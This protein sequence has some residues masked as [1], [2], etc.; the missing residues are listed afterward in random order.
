MAETVPLV[1]FALAGLLRADWAVGLLF[2]A[3][4]VAGL[5]VSA[6]SGWMGRVRR[7]G[8]GIALSAAVWRP[9]SAPSAS[10]PTWWWRCCCW[11]WRGRVTW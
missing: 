7:Y 3:E 11:S 10:H 6:T 5:L 9:P 1:V 8:L 2:S 4:A